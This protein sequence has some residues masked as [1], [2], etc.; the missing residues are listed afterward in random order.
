MKELLIVA[1]SFTS[2]FVGAYAFDTFLSWRD[3]RK[4][5]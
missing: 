1:V 2:G 5:R 3:D 4:W